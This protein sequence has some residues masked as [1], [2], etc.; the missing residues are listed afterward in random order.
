MKKINLTVLFIFLLSNLFA[1]EK[2]PAFPG[3]EG[4]G[5]YATGGRGGRVVEVTTLEDYKESDTPIEG[6]LRKA[7]KTEGDDPVNIIFRVSGRIDLKEKL[8]CGRK[9]MT[10]A[11]QTA[12]GDGICISGN[13][14]YFSGQ[15]LII[16]YLR[17]R[18]GD[19]QG[20]NASCVN[21]ENAE[22]V[23]V[24]HCSF[25]WSM[26]ENMTVYDNK[27]TTV[28][29][30]II[31]EPLYQSVHDKGKR[32]YGMQ[33][34][35][36]YASYHHNL[37]AHAYS[38]APRVNG[39]RTKNDVEVVNDF[40]N[41][42][43]YNWGKTNSV[44]GGEAEVENGYCYTNW[45]NNFYKPG[46]AS[47]KKSYY[48][49]ASYN[50]SKAAGYGKWYVSGNYFDDA[51]YATAN[52]D[53]HKGMNYK[54]GE[55]NQRSDERFQVEDVTTSTAAQAYSDVLSHAGARIPC[56]D[57]TDKRILA[58]AKGEITPV[59]GGVLGTTKGIIDSQADVDG[60]VEYKSGTAPV[61]TDK[62][63]MPDDWEIENALNPNDPV[64][65]TLLTENGYS[66]LEM[67][68]NSIAPTEEDDTPLTDVKL[69][70]KT[71]QFYLDLSQR[72][73]HVDAPLMLKEISIYNSSGVKV[74]TK[75]LQ[76]TKYTIASLDF[77]P[78]GIYILGCKLS[79]GKYEFGKILL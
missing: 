23:I 57:A 76:D 78:K 54:G 50:S 45:M 70:N 74:F 62:D 41:N 22:N 6:S 40:V 53:N 72:I 11:G 52:T 61:D 30:C 28:Q 20:V 27:Y 56:L 51:S 10:I 12:P 8:K 43:I 37:I 77:L 2:I 9:N 15:N 47:P 13:N 69:Q 60:W 17:F 7:L 55:A 75:T 32:G 24:D 58:E 21:I 34:G 44:Y 49:E 19:L 18:T 79:D 1:D 5:K 65:G 14:I 64:D 48:A 46:P 4:F 73:V 63:G 66:N 42:V 33:W 59:Y 68:L 67:Y 29:W 25:S 16:R 71:I 26:E 36:R 31:S 3:A 38:R 35:G 39:S